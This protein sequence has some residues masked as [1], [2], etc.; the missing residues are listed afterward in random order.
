MC[1]SNHSYL[2]S[3]SLI[4][5]SITKDV[6]FFNPDG[7]TFLAT[8]QGTLLH[9]HNW[10]VQKRPLFTDYKGLISFLRLYPGLEQYKY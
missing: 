10:K 1:F 3:Y 8:Y 9:F 6:K 2:L 5:L 4:K 7:F